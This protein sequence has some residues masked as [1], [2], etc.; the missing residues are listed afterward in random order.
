MT[1]PII[2]GFS[3]K[4]DLTPILPPIPSGIRSV[5]FSGHGECLETRN[6]RGSHQSNADH[7]PQSE[8]LLTTGQPN[9][10]ARV[11]GQI[12]FTR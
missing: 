6:E 4:P 8:M 11:G 9:N 1:N 5:I 10:Q 12:W 2:G 3:S 7:R